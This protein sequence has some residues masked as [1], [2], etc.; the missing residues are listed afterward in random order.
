MGEFFVRRPVFAMVIS[1]LILIVGLV[2]MGRLPIAQYPDIT[3]PEIKVEATYDGANAVNV[4]QSVATPLEQ[5]VNGVENMLYMKSTNAGN[6]QM[7]LSVAFEVGSDQDI[8]NVLVQNRVSEGAAQLPEEVKRRGVKIKKALAFPLMLVTLRSPN[9]SFDADFLTNYM[10][11]NVLDEVSR[12]QG[13]GQVTIFGGSITYHLGV[14][15]LCYLSFDPFKCTSTNEK[16]IFCNIIKCVVYD[17][18]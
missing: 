10:S 11:I 17:I 13:V 7:T 12:I 6:G 2:A 8:S 14:Q 15:A 5:K 3:P 4:E 9:G 16:N 18:C 1:I